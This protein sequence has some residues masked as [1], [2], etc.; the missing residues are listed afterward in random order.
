MYGPPPNCKQNQIGG[1]LLSVSLTYTDY[2]LA[3][4]NLRRRG[5]VGGAGWRLTP[6]VWS[7][8]KLQ[9][10]SDRRAAFVRFS[11]IHRLCASES[12]F[13]QTRACWRGWLAVDATCMV[14]HQTARRIRSEGGFCPFL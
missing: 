2:A 13:T 12:E 7:A 14:R 3:N 5:H 6:H 1:R 8:T 9:A 11:D 10:E 4:R